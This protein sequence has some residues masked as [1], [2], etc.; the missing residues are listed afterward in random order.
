MHLQ[1]VPILFIFSGESL[2]TSLMAAGKSCRTGPTANSLPGASMG[3]NNH[4]SLKDRR[5]TKIK[6]TGVPRICSLVS[7][8]LD[9]SHG[10]LC[11]SHRSDNKVRLLKSLLRLP[12]VSDVS[13]V[14]SSGFR[15]VQ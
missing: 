11:W 9:S 7:R 5:W 3:L 14:K 4:Q 2:W 10:G 15:Q 1:I 6:L 8:D 13:I 12:L